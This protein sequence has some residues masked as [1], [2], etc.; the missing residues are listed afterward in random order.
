MNDLIKESLTK[1]KQKDI[2]LFY[3]L[4]NKNKRLDL[5]NI[6]SKTTLKN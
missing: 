3:P 1:L 2:F 6:L 4:M 5:K